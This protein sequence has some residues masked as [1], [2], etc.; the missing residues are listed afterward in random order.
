MLST[1]TR[2]IAL[3]LFIAAVVLLI[4]PP[5]AKTPVVDSSRPNQDGRPI[6][7]RPSVWADALSLKHHRRLAKYDPGI[8]SG[9]L[10]GAPEC[11]DCDGMGGQYIPESKRREGE[12]DRTTCHTCQGT[13]VE[14]MH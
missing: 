5:R 11:R 12:P 14:G 7:W 8:T 3:V 10:S 1:K 9:T 6:P 2:G 13:G 4:P